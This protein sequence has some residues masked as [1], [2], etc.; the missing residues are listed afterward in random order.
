VETFQ[1]ISKAA[2]TA[3]T[4][5]VLSYRFGDD[6]IDFEMIAQV[7][8]WGDSGSG[9][10]GRRIPRSDR[11]VR[12]PLPLLLDMPASDDDNS[13]HALTVVAG[14]QHAAAAVIMKHQR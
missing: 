12:V 11:P 10:M 6:C 1:S 8:G 9:Q 3:T 4:V 7:F 13:V 2:N 14:Y 5:T